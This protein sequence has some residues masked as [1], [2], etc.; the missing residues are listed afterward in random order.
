MNEPTR[1]FALLGDAGLRRLIQQ[2]WRDNG[3]VLCGMHSEGGDSIIEEMSRVRP[4]LVLV[5]ADVD[6]ARQ[7]VE[8][9]ST[10]YR[11]PVVAIVRTEQSGLSVLRPLEWGAVAVAPRGAQSNA[12]LLEQVE[13]AV[14][15]ARHAQVVEVLESHFPLSGAFPDATVF[16][17]RRALRSVDPRGKIV[18]VA[19]GLGGP[20]AMRRILT[21]LEGNVVS[22]VVLAQRADEALVSPLVQW[23]EYHTGAEVVKTASGQ[24]LE[25]G[26]VYVASG[27]CDVLVEK[28]HAEPVLKV[29]QSGGGS[30]PSFDRLFASV[31]QAYGSRAVAVLLSGEGDDGVEGLLAVRRA[32]G[33]TIVQDR[34]SSL[35]H[36]TPGRARDAGGAVEC[37]PINEI[38]ERL[39]MLMRPD[40]P[41]R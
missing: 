15:Q 35:V 4:H 26:Q 3:K 2:R 5:D 39:L 13:A 22:P 33:F 40:P 23:L 32:G 36:D 16:D 7:V 10:R 34:T 19:A 20:M 31:A 41:S 9:A 28:H 11:L 12:E 6:G 29:S 14:A 30:A 37:L 21:E 8:A 17:M 27:G 24:R 18:V 38:A 1:V 25:V